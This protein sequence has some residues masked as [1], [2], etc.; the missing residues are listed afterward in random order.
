M[1]AGTRLAALLFLAFSF[2]AVP[3]L[4][5][6]DCTPV[7]IPSTENQATLSGE[8]PFLDT[9]C[10]LVTLET[11]AMVSIFLVEGSELAL[12]VDV[13]DYSESNR[14][15]FPAYEPETYEVYVGQDASQEPRPFQ[16]QILLGEDLPPQPPPDTRPRI[17][18]VYLVDR[19]NT[20][21][22]QEGLATDSDARWKI[23]E[24]CGDHRECMLEY[25]LRD[26]DKTG[27]LCEDYY[28]RLCQLALSM[29]VPYP[30]TYSCT[31][32]FEEYC[33]TNVELLPLEGTKFC[34]VWLTLVSQTELGRHRVIATPDKVS[35][36][37]EAIGS[38]NEFDRF[39]SWS[40]IKVATQMV[41][42]ELVSDEEYAQ[43]CNAVNYDLGD[44]DLPR[45]Y[46]YYERLQRDGYR[47]VVASVP[48]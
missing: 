47:E 22:A 17:Y 44:T 48:R 5:Q 32:R 41:I 29:P 21:K 46:S 25:W 15:D 11:P 37:I 14:Y 33:L 19:W 36:H 7:T 9:A 27:E 8:A 3:A 1:L 4:A 35:I 10:F 23:I 31:S 30:H 34:Y 18:G 43:H 13:M 40:T 45:P 26:E 38:S 28:S 39:R 2:V 42:T 6:E 12:S 24:I 20:F 16:V